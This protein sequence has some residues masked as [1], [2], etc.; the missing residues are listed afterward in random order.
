MALSLDGVVLIGHDWG[1]A[2]ALD[3][4]ARH[5]GRIR[6]IAFTRVAFAMRASKRPVIQQ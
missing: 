2:L 6:G 3:W 1:G 4:A 5:P